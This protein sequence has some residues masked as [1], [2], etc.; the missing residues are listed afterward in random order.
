MK[1]IK[2]DVVVH[3]P[4]LIEVLRD[5]P[6]LDLT[7]ARVI[8]NATPEDIE[9]KTVVG[10]LPMRLAALAHRYFELTL[11]L[12]PNLWGKE[13][14]TDQVREHLEGL[15][16]YIVIR[17]SQQQILA[18]LQGDDLNWMGL[19]LYKAPQGATRKIL[20]EGTIE[21]V[22]FPK[23]PFGIISFSPAGF[24]RSGDGVEGAIVPRIEDAGVHGPLTSRL[25][26]KAIQRCDPPRRAG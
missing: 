9:G 12:P 21:Q 20:E 7:Q 5:L 16:E 1:S 13:L 15:E 24:Y 3:H 19:Q 22:A 11:D 10:V 6:G 25:R 2:I 14:S 8:P 23:I 4:A 17:K 26:T 18:L